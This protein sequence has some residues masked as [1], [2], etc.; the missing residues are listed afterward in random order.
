MLQSASGG[1]PGRGGAW[2][3]MSGLGGCLVRVCLV[4]GVSAPR[5]CLDW[6]APGPG[7]GG[8]CSWGG[9]VSGLGGWGW[10]C[11]LMGGWVS[12]YALRQTPLPPVDRQTL[13]KILPWANFVAAGKNQKR[14]ICVI[15]ENLD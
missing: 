6:G 12:Q 3:G 9:G 5:G 1:V 11:L 8:V 7:E 13:V 14:Q 15:Y 4:W 10:G 2:Y